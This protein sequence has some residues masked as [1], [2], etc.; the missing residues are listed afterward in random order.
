MEETFPIKGHDMIMVYHLEQLS[1]DSKNLSKGQTA[2]G[3]PPSESL[4]G[5]ER[6]NEDLLVVGQRNTTD[7]DNSLHS[8][9]VDIVEENTTHNR[10]PA[11]LTHLGKNK[12]FPANQKGSGK[13]KGYI[14]NIVHSASQKPERAAWVKRV[15]WW[16]ENLKGRSRQKLGIKAYDYVPS[17]RHLP[18][19]RRFVKTAVIKHLHR[20][21]LSQKQG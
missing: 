2:R 1:Q 7:S 3:K 13:N 15:S 5:I 20:Y 14:Q 17:S 12:G 8:E 18:T 16:T 4:G 9:S 21:L 19:R 6:S 10:R 11:R